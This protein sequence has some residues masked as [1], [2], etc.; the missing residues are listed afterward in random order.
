MCVLTLALS[1][2]AS[3]I[4]GVRSLVVRI[5]VNGKDRDV[6]D[7]SSIGDLVAALGY[8]NKQVVVEHNGAAVERTRFAEIVLGPQDVIEVVRPVQGGAR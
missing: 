7:G 6:A 3:T 2:R 4:A 8:G 5:T 1:D